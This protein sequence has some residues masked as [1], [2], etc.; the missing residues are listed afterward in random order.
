MLAIFRLYTA[1]DFVK[2]IENPNLYPDI[3][4]SED[5]FQDSFMVNTDRVFEL[6]ATDFD[7]GGNIVTEVIEAED[8]LASFQIKSEQQIISI[9]AF[10]IKAVP[11][12][13]YPLWVRLQIYI[14][15]TSNGDPDT[16]RHV[17]NILDV[18]QGSTSDRIDNTYNTYS[19]FLTLAED[20]YARDMGTG[21]YKV[22]AK[23]KITIERFPSEEVT[24]V[25][26]ILN[27]QLQ[28]IY[29]A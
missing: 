19:M 25:F 11:P 8:E 24:G 10:N 7:A 4:D 16:N 27:N 5:D 2:L 29:R 14:V 15:N 3:S 9:P 21:Q 18:G 20:L 6:I 13:N 1:S 26:E 23:Y 28:V 17:L 12:T 22:I